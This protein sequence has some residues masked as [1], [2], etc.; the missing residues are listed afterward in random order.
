MPQSSPLVAATP[1]EAL[2]ILQHLDAGIVSVNCW[3]KALHGKLICDDAS[4][5]ADLAEDPRNCNFSRWFHDDA[6]PE[7]RQNR[8]FQK[9]GKLHKAMHDSGHSLLQ[10]K[11]RHLPV[12]VEEYNTFMDLATALKEELHNLQFE[13]I[14]NACVVDQLTGA[15]NRHAM[16]SK[17]VQELERMIRNKQS[18]SICMLDIDHFKQVNDQHGHDAGDRALIATAH[19]LSKTRRAGDI[20]ARWGGEEFMLLLPETDLE[21]AC[22]LAERMR[23]GIEAQQLRIAQETI[24]LTASFGIAGRGQQA[25]LEDLISEADVQLYEA[26]QK[27]RNR[28]ASAGMVFSGN[29]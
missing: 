25:R 29:K 22:A 5:S 28:V 20:L 23:H 2:R 3:L 10:K 4:N 9:A 19:L 21:Q 11:T 16:H 12:T 27:G 17:L 6:T 13:V 1:Q 26:K 7:L 18:C 8:M 15:W 14:N 24:S